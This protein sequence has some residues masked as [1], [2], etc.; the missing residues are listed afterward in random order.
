MYSRIQAEIDLDAICNNIEEV[1]RTVGEKASVMAI[2]KADGYG[3]GAIPIA[4]ALEEQVAGFGVAAVQEAENLRRAGIKKMILI[5]GYTPAEYYPELVADD[6][7]QTVFEYEMA[8]KLNAAA[9]KQGRK[10]R[11][12]IK[13]DTG[14]GRIG[15]ADCEES[16]GILKKIS[17]LPNLVIEG[18]FTHFACADEVDKTSARRQMERFE[19]FCEMAEAR[20]INLGI[21]HAANSAA[22]ID[23]PPAW[24]DMVRSGIATY[25]MY[26]SE[27][28]NKRRLCLRPALSLKSHVVYVKDVEAGN[29]ISYGSTYVTERRTRIATIPVGYADGYP[30]SLSSKGFVLIHGKR[31]QILGRVCMDQMMVDVTELPEVK[32]GDSV[33]LIGADGGDC[34]TVEEIS[35][36]AGTFN[37]EFVCNLS[38]RVPRIYYRNG[39]VVGSMDYTKDEMNAVEYRG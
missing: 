26:P 10:A 34:I 12:H 11:I 24:Y 20:G 25:G 1:K 18:I 27:E 38:K 28:V 35:A 16:I 22:I 13:V 33:T 7:S 30:R 6:I 17:E 39:K 8:E 32:T 9:Q 5:L 19:H 14:M 29:G 21:R 37:Y 4:Y 3:H 2:I 15:F 31:A 36:L 23:L